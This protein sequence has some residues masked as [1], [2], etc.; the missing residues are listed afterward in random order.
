MS[1]NQNSRADS[2]AWRY[3]VLTSFLFSVG[4]TSFG[5]LLLPVD[6]WVKGYMAMGLYFALASTVMLSKTL[7]DDFESKKLINKI[8]EAQTKKMLKEYDLAT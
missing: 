7:R 1:N 8:N 3:F 4:A 6:M 5:L 2:V